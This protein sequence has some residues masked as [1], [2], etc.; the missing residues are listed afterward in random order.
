MV[1]ALS[2]YSNQQFNAELEIGK[3]CNINILLFKENAHL[4][5]VKKVV[6]DHLIITHVCAAIKI[7][8]NAKRY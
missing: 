1:R 5:G 2:F 6:I 7:K 3:C 8:K 4:A